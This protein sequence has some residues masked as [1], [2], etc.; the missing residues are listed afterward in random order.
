MMLLKPNGLFGNYEIPF[1]RQVLPALRKKPSP[2]EE[3]SK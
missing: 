2:A 3:V 1:L